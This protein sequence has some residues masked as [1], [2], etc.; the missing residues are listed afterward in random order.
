[1]NR[2]TERQEYGWNLLHPKREARKE[3]NDKIRKDWMVKGRKKERKEDRAGEGK[4]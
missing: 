4:K 2:T 1:L 3:G